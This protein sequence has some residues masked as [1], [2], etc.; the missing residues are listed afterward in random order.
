[1]GKIDYPMYLQQLCEA[2]PAPK[3]AVVSKVVQVKERGNK[4][5]VAAIQ[6]F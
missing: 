4:N 3:G 6:N 5:R 2:T 1:M